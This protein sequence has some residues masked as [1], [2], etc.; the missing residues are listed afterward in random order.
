[1]FVFVFLS[2]RESIL[3]NLSQM[4]RIFSL[5]RRYMHCIHLSSTRLLPDY[6]HPVWWWSSCRSSLITLFTPFDGGIH[7]AHLLPDSVHPVWRWSSCRSSFTR[8]CSPSLT[9]EFMSLIFSVFCVM[10]FNI[11]V[12]PVFCFVCWLMSFAFPF[13]RLLGVR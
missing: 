11:Y 4:T 12:F 7:V 2:G 13:G 1:M 8:L 3:G 6:V 10:C 9:V 5:L